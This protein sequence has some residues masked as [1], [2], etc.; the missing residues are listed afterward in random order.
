MDT[1][2][3]PPRLVYAWVVGAVL[4]TAIGVVVYGVGQQAAR[5]AVDDIPRAMLEQA[6]GRLSAG[7]PPATAVE[8]P[9][10]DLTNG[11]AP[12]VLVYDNEHT[13]VA[14]SATIAGT[15]PNLPLDRPRRGDGS[16]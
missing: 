14:S 12:F 5:S 8:G 9:K 2:R 13:L 16:R 11:D 15:T 6:R 4:V 1:G 10:V 7:V 3:I